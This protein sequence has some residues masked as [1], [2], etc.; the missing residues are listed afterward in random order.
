MPCG[1]LQHLH[2]E[3]TLTTKQ[4]EQTRATARATAERLRLGRAAGANE[5]EGFL[6]RKLQRL[7]A[8]IE[9]HKNEHGCSE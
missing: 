4:L 3:A 5:F 9:G 6:Q 7:A 8:E 2:E 1:T